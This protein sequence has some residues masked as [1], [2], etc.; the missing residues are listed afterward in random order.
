VRQPTAIDAGM[1]DADAVRHGGGRGHLRLWLDGGGE[2]TCEVADHGGGIAGGHVNGFERP[3]M[4]VPGGWGLWLVRRLS[5]D[6]RV[7]TGPNGTA[8]RI[9][10]PR[11]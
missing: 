9:T 5:V 4:D 8:V 2:L 10:A 7:T 3:A 1:V 11:G 6:M